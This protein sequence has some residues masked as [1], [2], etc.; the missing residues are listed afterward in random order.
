MFSNSDED[1]FDIENS[2]IVK[3]TTKFIPITKDY[4]GEKFFV[5]RDGSGWERFCCW[6]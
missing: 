2:G 5:V 1:E 6:F 4:E 3:L